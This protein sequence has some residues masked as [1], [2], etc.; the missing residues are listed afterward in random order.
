MAQRAVADGDAGVRH[1]LYA[2]AISAGYYHAERAF[3]SNAITPGGRA[4]TRGSIV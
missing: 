3:S 1:Q 2:A 4:S